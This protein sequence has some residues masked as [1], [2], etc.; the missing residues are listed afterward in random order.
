MP[1]AQG[2]VR[3]QRSLSEKQALIVEIERRMKVQGRGV[4]PVANQL[5]IAVSTYYMWLSAGM[6]PTSDRIGR[7]PSGDM[8]PRKEAATRTI[9]ESDAH[10]RA[11]IMAAVRAGLAEGVPI[12]TT[13]RQHGITEGVFYRWAREAGRVPVSK[14]V[15]ISVRSQAM[16]V[17]P[18]QTPAFR[19]VTLSA[20][21][22]ARALSLVAPSGHRIEG[23][24]VETAAAL[25]RALS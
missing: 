10:E 12:K 1:D 24:S 19:A 2:H 5:G 7:V 18:P 22:P 9:G 13:T 17:S 8:A 11:R 23:L 14:P 21:E 25:L 20:A 4:K 15:P 16:V 6:R 3:K